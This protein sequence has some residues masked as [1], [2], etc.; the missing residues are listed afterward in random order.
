MTTDPRIERAGDRPV[1][2]FGPGVP[3]HE[4]FLDRVSA[5][6]GAE[7][8]TAADSDLDIDSALY[9]LPFLDNL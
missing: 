4:E 1:H 7:L 5:V 3:T 8:L 9:C 2:R 6:S